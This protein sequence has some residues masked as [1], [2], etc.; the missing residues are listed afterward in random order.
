MN[1]ITEN[2]TAL[3]S[4]APRPWRLRLLFGLFVGIAAFFLISEHRAHLLVGLVW[5]PWLLLLACPLMHVF[6]HGRH[7]H[8]HQ[9]EHATQDA[10]TSSPKTSEPN[11]RLDT[12][13]GRT[14]ER[15]R[16]IPRGGD[17]P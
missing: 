10:D 1:L 16:H 15:H 11:D 14:V 12:T 17:L 7:G 5:L 8:G 6:G 9:H 4:P 2:K 13:S 3:I